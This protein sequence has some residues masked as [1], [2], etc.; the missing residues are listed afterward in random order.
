MR[1]IEAR[2][3]GAVLAL[4]SDEIYVLSNALN[5]ICNGVDIPE[6]DTRIGATKIA[7]RGLLE[8]FVRVIEEIS[9]K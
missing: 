1:K 3:D 6:F 4:S 5:E 2:A 7:V 8:E 9:D